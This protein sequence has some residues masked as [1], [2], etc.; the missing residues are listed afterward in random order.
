VLF[1]LR[2]TPFDQKQLGAGSVVAEVGVALVSST[3]ARVETPLA[4]SPPLLEHAAVAIASAVSIPKN[5]R[6][7]TNI[8]FARSANS[9][10]FGKHR[11]GDETDR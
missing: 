6:Y 9:D 10:E 11:L 5:V 2:V 1:S 8:S 3:D 4:W 7:R